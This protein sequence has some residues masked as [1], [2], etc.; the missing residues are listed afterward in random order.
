MKSLVSKFAVIPFFFCFCLCI[1]SITKAE[2]VPLY[3]VQEASQIDVTVS[4]T[5]WIH[6]GTQTPNAEVTAGNGRQLTVTNHMPVGVRIVGMQAANAPASA[7]TLTSYQNDFTAYAADSKQY[8][9][10]Y[11][12][13]ADTTVDLFTQQDTNCLV[14][15]YEDYEV[16]LTAKLSAST[17]SISET[18]HIVVG[19]VV[20]RLDF[21]DAEKPMQ[22]ESRTITLNADAIRLAD[23]GAVNDAVYA[24]TKQDGT[25]MYST[26]ADFDPST[27]TDI[28]SI[29]IWGETSVPR[30]YLADINKAA[31]DKIW[32]SDYTDIPELPQIS[33]YNISD[34]NAVGKGKEYTD[35]LKSRYS[36]AENTVWQYIASLGEDYFVGTLA[37]YQLFGYTKYV[38]AETVPYNPQA[39]IWTSLEYGGSSAACLK[40]GS[41]YREYDYGMINKPSRGCVLPLLAF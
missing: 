35:I 11:Q 18:D 2:T 37:E 41:Y 34:V 33:N 12:P 20:L 17:V 14:N 5:L 7:Y 40:Y 28:K 6:A 1:P 27:I 36:D 10:A 4:D 19:N 16:P 22:L 23:T 15:P 13:D 32:Q 26:D 8:A 38:S 31:T 39:D 25:T 30:F 29:E 9:L 24:F 3:A 21:D